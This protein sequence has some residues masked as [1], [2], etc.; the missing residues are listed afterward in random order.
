[1]ISAFERA[2]NEWSK[3][4]DGHGAKTQSQLNY[5]HVDLQVLY[6]LRD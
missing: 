2:V 3:D 4:G 6:L 5:K 1:M